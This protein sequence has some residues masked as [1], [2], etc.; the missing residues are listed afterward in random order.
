M[1]P[2]QVTQTLLSDVATI[3]EKARA[4]KEH[5]RRYAA[6]ARG[7]GRGAAF[8]RMLARSELHKR[9][10]D[11]SQ[12]KLVDALVQ[13]TAYIQQEERSSLVSPPVSEGPEITGITGT[14]GPTRWRRRRPRLEPPI[15]QRSVGAATCALCSAPEC[16]SP[17]R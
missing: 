9:C 12:R 4:L 11:E 13:V 7:M 1:D 10:P 3:D 6:T 17:L 16:Y 15:S 5:I 8:G 2:E 14:Q